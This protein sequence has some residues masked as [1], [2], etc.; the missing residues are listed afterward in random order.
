[1]LMLSTCCVVTLQREIYS[2]WT[3]VTYA[4]WTSA[5]VLNMVVEQS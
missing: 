1:V 3:D 5:T 4:N 2:H